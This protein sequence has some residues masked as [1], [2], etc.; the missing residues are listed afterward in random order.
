MADGKMGRWTSCS[1][2][3]HEIGTWTGRMDEG[4]EAIRIALRLPESIQYPIVTFRA[5]RCQGGGAGLAEGMVWRLGLTLS[6]ICTD[7]LC[8]TDKTDKWRECRHAQE[9]G[10]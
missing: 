9:S 3:A 10:T 5:A 7:P 6:S 8:G 1:K 4:E 2:T